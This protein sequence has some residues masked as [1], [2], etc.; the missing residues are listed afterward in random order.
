[1]RALLIK[2]A[3]GYGLVFICGFFI[4]AIFFF[5]GGKT[6]Q[7]AADAPLGIKI[8]QPL[9]KPSFFGFIRPIAG[10]FFITSTFGPRWGRNH[11]GVDMG[12]KLGQTPILAAKSGR[13]FYCGFGIYGQGYGGYGNTVVID[14]GGGIYS[15]YA[16]MA[17]LTVTR[18]QTVK[19]GQSIGVCG[20]TGHSLGAH[21]HFEVK[22]GS[23]YG[24]QVDPMP[25]LP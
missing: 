14:H 7:I 12:C 22:I 10:P 1:M 6:L 13:V 20:N 11:N 3:I 24:S 19:G 21:L 8:D 4:L 15:L 9:I 16:H 18:G 2:K 17:L 5:F 23:P 25:F